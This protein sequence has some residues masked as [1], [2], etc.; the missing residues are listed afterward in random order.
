MKFHEDCKV[1][2]FGLPMGLLYMYHV[3]GFTYQQLVETY[4]A[5]FDV[6]IDSLKRHLQ[7]HVDAKDIEFVERYAAAHS[8]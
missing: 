1:C 7:R 6:D 3:K 5:F 8:S 2:N 4:K